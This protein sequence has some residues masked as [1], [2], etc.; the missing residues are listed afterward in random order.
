MTG[1]RPTGPVIAVRSG[2]ADVVTYRA[3]NVIQRSGDEGV[4]R[5]WRPTVP[6][7]EGGSDGPERRPASVLVR[8][9]STSGLRTERGGP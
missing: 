1:W 2:T 9:G 4:S 3:R 6:C 5:P 8:F 7:G